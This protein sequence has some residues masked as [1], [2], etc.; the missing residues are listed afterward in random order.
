MGGKRLGEGMQRAAPNRPSSAGLT[1]GPLD[2][3]IPDQVGDD[4]VCTNA[5]QRRTGGRR[6]HFAI[7]ALYTSQIRLQEFR[8]ADLSQ[9]DGPSGPVRRWPG[10]ACL[11]LIPCF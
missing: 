10:G 3:E 6:V 1:R 11:A 2:Q 9:S 8:C 4:A 5:C 7:N